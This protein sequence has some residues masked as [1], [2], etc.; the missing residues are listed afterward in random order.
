VKAIFSDLEQHFAALNS[1]GLGT[2]TS[3]EIRTEIARVM[4]FAYMRKLAPS[5]L[6]QLQRRSWSGASTGACGGLNRTRRAEIQR[7]PTD[8]M[9]E[10]PRTTTPTPWSTFSPVSEAL[11]KRADY[12]SGLRY[13]FAPDDGICGI[14]LDVSLDGS[15]NPHDW[16]A[17]VIDR[18]RDTYLRRAR[19]PVTDYTSCAVP[20]YP[21]GDG[22]SMFRMDPWTRLV[23]G[24]K[25]GYLT[26]S[27]FS[28]WQVNPISP[29]IDAWSGVWW[30]TAATVDTG[31]SGGYV[32]RDT[33]CPSTRLDW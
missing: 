2:L 21:A 6:R 27:A 10:R 25:L 30:C 14:D 7:S 31:R 5:Q 22:T 24:H 29:L 9:G 12:F 11:V 26:E 17:E 19:S 23:R 16:A 15:G 4:F 13:F 20:R 18:C 8:R 28:R 32:H 3:A 33:L 1:L